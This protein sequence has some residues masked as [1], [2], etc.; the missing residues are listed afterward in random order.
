MK[1]AVVN[2]LGQPPRYEEFAEPLAGEGEAIV[3]M[4]AA[5]LHPIVKALA[6]GQHYS[7][8]GEV[9]FIAGVDGVGKL[10]DGKIA[11]C[12]AVRPP[13]GTMAQRTVVARAKCI[14]LPEGLDP[15]QAAAIANPGMS[16][17]LSLKSRAALVAGEV[18]LVNGATGAAGQLAVQAARYLGARKII[19]TGRN[20]EVL[21]MLGADATIALDEPEDAVSEAFIAQVRDGGIDIVIDY[22]W[23]RP[24]E[25]LLGALAKGFRPEGSRRI[26]LVE[27]GE[28]AGKAISLPG[29]VLRSMDLNLC[30]SG[31]GSVPLNEIMNAIPTL[32]SLAA[33]GH[34]SVA[35]ES[36]PLVEVEAAWTRTEKGKRIV[37]S[38]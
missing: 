13:Y 20:R 8:K 14:P 21:A 12:L 37:F 26:R 24:T 36:V 34:L 27:V 15:A 2:T 3:E 9:P 17:W 16:A 35:V 11:Y 33:G 5:G 29:A 10:E 23:G 19:A 31:F 6:S 28:S 30:G 38:I 1:A 32:F 7:S 22:L 4:Q 25:L 18:V